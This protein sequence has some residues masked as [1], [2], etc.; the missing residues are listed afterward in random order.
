[1]KPAFEEHSVDQALG[2]ISD[3]LHHPSGGY[4]APSWAEAHGK[5]LLEA[6]EQLKGRMRARHMNLQHGAFPV[7]MYAARE[8]RKYLAGARSDISNQDAAQVFYRCLAG[9]IDELRP[10]DQELAKEQ[11][12]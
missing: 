4:G 6:L 1:M 10:L 9:L 8:F 7:A 5:D 12:A 11:A 3:V 2:K